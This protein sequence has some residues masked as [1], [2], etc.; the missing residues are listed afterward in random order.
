MSPQPGRRTLTVLAPTLRRHGALAAGAARRRSHAGAWGRAG[1][2][3]LM[4]QFVGVAGLTP[5]GGY[6]LSVLLK[7]SWAGPVEKASAGVVCFE[8]GH[9]SPYVPDT[10]P[11]NAVGPVCAE[12]EDSC[13]E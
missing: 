5:T 9:H 7:I 6:Q 3:G 11:E 4:G 10:L 12:Q 13:R 8:R 1:D 2:S